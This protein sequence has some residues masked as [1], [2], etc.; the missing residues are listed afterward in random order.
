MILGLDYTVDEIRAHG[1]D[2]ACRT[3]AMHASPPF[4]PLKSQVTVLGIQ[5]PK[6][7]PR[8][9]SM[10]LRRCVCVYLNIKYREQKVI[11][12][13]PHHLILIGLSLKR[14]APKPK[15][16]NIIRSLVYIQTRAVLV[17]LLFSVVP[18]DKILSWTN[19]TIL[20][21]VFRVSTEQ[22]FLEDQRFLILDDARCFKE[23]QKHTTKP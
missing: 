11:C 6:C 20:S 10:I 18:Q 4:S 21:E 12:M 3:I 14:D 15:S 1:Q 23:Y 9:G 8:R 22:W 17:R 5:C 13:T 19:P 16:K 2:L 7:P